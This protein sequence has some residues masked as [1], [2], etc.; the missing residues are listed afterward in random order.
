[1]NEHRFDLILLL[2]F[3]AG[4]LLIFTPIVQAGTT[5]YVDDDAPNDP[6][7][8]DPDVS[9]PLEDGS[10]DHPFDAIQEGIDAA[11]GGDTVLVADGTY[12]GTGNRDIDFGGK[13]ITVRSENGLHH[14][15]IDIEGD[16][17]SGFT[18]FSGEGRDSVAQ[19]FTIKTM[20]GAG[21]GQPGIYCDGSSPTIMNNMI[22]GFKVYDAGGGIRCILNASPLIVGN[23]IYNNMADDYPDPAFGGGIYCD[24]D[25]API[26]INN[27]IE[28]NYADWLGGGIFCSSA[29]ATILNNVITC[30]ESGSDG[31]GI[32]CHE[33]AAIIKNNIISWNNSSGTGGGIYCHTEGDPA[34]TGNVIIGNEA[35]WGGG[36]SFYSAGS[37]IFKNNLIV[38]NTAIE[39]GGG[40]YYYWLNPLHVIN[41]TIAGNTAPTGG[42][43]YCDGAD[44]TVLNSIFWNNAPDGIFVN[45]GM[46]TIT[47]SDVQGGYP[48][49]GNIDAD[50]IFVRGPL[51]SYYLS[52]IAAGQ[53]QNSPCVDTGDGPVCLSISANPAVF[54]TTRT[55]L[56]P[57]SGI[58]D[59][60]YHYPLRGIQIPPGAL[61]EE[62]R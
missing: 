34:I 13:A 14:C 58:I 56:V 26:I 57:D 7:P 27:T 50:P 6:G 61:L 59:M 38:G 17:Y 60:G 62:I 5:W 39:R 45:S 12:T 32:F 30:N 52:Q 10:T 24:R 55:D 41:N 18:F 51:G 19:G 22:T 25:S 47:Y 2:L 16:N 42:G 31:G 29:P 35:G 33:S 37:S 1:M 46:V 21:R 20:E 54:G 53:G 3:I 48:G 8:G 49:T 28:G 9:D 43:I 15:V 44:L 11:T 36:V 23:I 4:G 40:I